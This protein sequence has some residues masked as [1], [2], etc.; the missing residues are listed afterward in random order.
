MIN[1][2]AG[3]DKSL[4]TIAK[5]LMNNYVSQKT[6]EEF[7]KEN[8]EWAKEMAARGASSY[9]TIQAFQE[10]KN[11]EDDARRKREEADK[12]EAEAQKK[13]EEARKKEEEAQRKESEGAADSISS[14]LNSIYDF[15]TGSEFWNKAT[16]ISTKIGDTIGGIFDNIKNFDLQESLT[17]V[18]TG[19]GSMFG[20]LLGGL[21]GEDRAGRF[22]GIFQKV[23]SENGF[24]GLANFAKS[25]RVSLYSKV[26]D[27]VS[28]AS[29][30]NLDIAEI[31]KL[32]TEAKEQGWDLGNASITAL[33]SDESIKIESE[34]RKSATG[35]R[36]EAIDKLGSEEK[37]A[38][39]IGKYNIGHKNKNSSMKVAARGTILS[40]DIPQAHISSHFGERRK[41]KTSSGQ[42]VDD[43]H[44]GIDI[45]STSA[46]APSIFAAYEGKIARAD[47]ADPNGYGNL[48]AIHHTIGGK[49]YTT[50]YAHLEKFADGIA[51]SKK[52]VKAGEA[53]GVMGNTGKSS[54]RH[55]HFGVY[56]GHL[57]SFGSKASS[58]AINPIPFLEMIAN[59]SL[60]HSIS[61]VTQIP[62]ADAVVGGALSST[63]TEPTTKLPI[64]KAALGKRTYVALSSLNGQKAKEF[65]NKLKEYSKTPTAKDLQKK[66]TDE[67]LAE[68]GENTKQ[69]VE[70]TEESNKKS[71][72]SGTTIINNITNYQRDLLN[73]WYSE[74]EIA[75]MQRTNPE[76]LSLLLQSVAGGF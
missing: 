23:A 47:N 75:E 41:F 32:L 1:R 51:G 19:L 2:I 25:A 17:K 64:E 27:L 6:Y 20:S 28:Y 42:L 60:I 3:I 15:F 14:K 36:K 29:R 59:G 53:I 61:D 44:D 21:F 76:Q 8:R 54:G 12:K 55:L 62:N 18:N 40:S 57:T 66:A 22:L 68:I 45:G 65:F 34:L 39:E 63:A 31:R 67:S 4:S 10:R 24:S 33:Q 9:D 74:K 49:P 70:A 11:Y 16:E 46:T 69:Q 30:N 72:T 43:V 37:Y 71:P 56:T 52:E 48:V 73:M 13:E 50:I 38:E 35:S 5:E 58:K 26:T 7:A